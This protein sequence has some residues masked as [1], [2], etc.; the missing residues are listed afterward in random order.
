[1]AIVAVVAGLALAVVVVGL[2]LA[3]LA[4][5][6]RQAQ[7]LYST[8]VLAI[9]TLTTLLPEHPANTIARLAIGSPGDT[10]W[11]AVLGALAI[12]AG[13]YVV[14]RLAVARI[15]LERFD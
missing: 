4:P 14:I 6:R 7:F 8:G 2:S 12:G 5:D 3:L 15:D 1:V 13:A 10:T 9:V 11:V